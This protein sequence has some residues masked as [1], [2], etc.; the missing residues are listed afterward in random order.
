M[1]RNNRPLTVAA[2][3]LACLFTT[4]GLTAAASPMATPSQPVTQTNVAA[5]DRYISFA[6]HPGDYAG[7]VYWASSAQTAKH[8]ALDN[9]NRAK[10]HGKYDCVSAGYARNAYLAVAVSGQHR[11]WGSAWSTDYTLAGKSARKTCKFYGGGDGCRV[12]FNRHSSER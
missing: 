1:F 7:W 5:A 3:V 11:A 9:C 2:L 4:T 6:F 10:S 12:I 8:A